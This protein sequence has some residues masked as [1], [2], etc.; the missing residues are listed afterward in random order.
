MEKNEYTYP[1]MFFG[2]SVKPLTNY[3]PD[4]LGRRL[5]AMSQAGHGVSYAAS[6]DHTEKQEESCL[7][8]ASCISDCSRRI[9]HW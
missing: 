6:T 7:T 5:L 4:E 8:S 2:T 1:Y 9:V 3:T